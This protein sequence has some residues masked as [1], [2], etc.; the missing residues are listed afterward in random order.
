M[1]EMKSRFVSWTLNVVKEIREIP[2][3]STSPTAKGNFCG[4]GINLALKSTATGTR[5]FLSEVDPSG[6]A[7]KAG[8]LPNDVFVEVDVVRFDDGKAYT[9]AD[10]A[11]AIRGP[12]G[13]TVGV[14][15][16]RDGKEVAFE[17]TREPIGVMPSIKVVEVGDK[18]AKEKLDHEEETEQEEEL[19]LEVE[20][21]DN[22]AIV[23]DEEKVKTDTEVK[24]ISSTINTDSIQSFSEQKKESPIKQDLSASNEETDQFDVRPAYYADDASE[25][26]TVDNEICSI[27]NSVDEHWELISERS[28]SAVVISFSGSISGASFRSA[29]PSMLCN[30]FV[31]TE[32]T[33]DPYIEHVVLPTDTLQG[34]C[35]AY[36]IS[37]TRLRME[38]GFSGNCLQMAPKKLKIPTNIKTY[39]KGM[40]IRTQDR[41]SKEFKLY[42]LVAEVPSMELVEAKAYLDLSNWDLEEALRSARED[43]GWHLKASGSFDNGVDFSPLLAV[44]KP[45]ALTAQDIYSVSNIV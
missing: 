31:L 18:A 42:A 27:I 39:T 20:A 30:K 16:E 25:E 15:V 14:V 4:V 26:K 45:K 35:L 21:E 32:S 17:L 6:P 43:D 38:N 8:L 28:G 1:A 13:S 29:S 9:P 34:I 40:M 41:T 3:A 12:E 11:K 7:S 10:V 37:A 33:G 44:A 24:G 23:C 22:T 2:A 36:K 5:V 19:K